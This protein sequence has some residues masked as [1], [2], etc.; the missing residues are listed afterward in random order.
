MKTSQV[1]FLEEARE[2]AENIADWYEKQ[3]TG[4]RK[5]F[6]QT[7]TN[8]A[9]ALSKNII[10]HRYFRYPAKYVKLKKFPYSI[11]YI[12]DETADIWI[13]IAVLGNK[14]DMLSIIETRI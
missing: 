1:I 3:H 2:D 13:I 12:Q 11:F 10:S 8:T 14:Q 9:Q 4:L 7:V 5:Q 6:L